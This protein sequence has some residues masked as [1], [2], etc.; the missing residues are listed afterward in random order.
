MTR[1]SGEPG[2]VDGVV[3]LR[4]RPEGMGD[5]DAQATD[6]LETSFID[7]MASTGPR[8]PIVGAER[9]DFEDSSIEFFDANATASVDNVDELPGR[10]S[11]VY[12]LGCAEGNFGVK[13]TADALM[14]DLLI[15]P[16]LSCG[17][18]DGA[19]R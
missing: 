18:P 1:Y 14:P 6:A 5:R 19:N 17:V 10:V 11:L 12:A 8:L 15:T 4:A 3:V 7:G 13:E 2:D 9:S 16:G